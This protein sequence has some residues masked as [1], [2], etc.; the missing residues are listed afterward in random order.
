[1]AYDCSYGWTRRRSRWPGGEGSPPRAVS[2]KGHRPRSMADR[3]AAKRADHFVGRLSERQRVGNALAANSDN[4]AA[5]ICFFGSG[6]IGKSTLLGKIRT[7]A[8]DASQLTASAEI[9]SATTPLDV[10]EQWIGS[11]EPD[12]DFKQFKKARRRYLGLEEKASRGP[13]GIGKGC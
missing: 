7:E 4:D 11:V 10:L 3:L 9:G 6:G 2:A 1:M 13:H 12:V 5:I 8:R